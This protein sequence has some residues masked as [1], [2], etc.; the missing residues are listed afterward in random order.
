[1]TTVWA[2]LSVGAI[3]V[4]V[5][6]GYNIVF[7]S[8]G[9]FN[10]AN[11]NLLM[12]G[13]FIAYWGLAQ[14]GLPV[15]VVFIVAGLGVLAIAGLEERIAF[16]PV[17]HL[18]G[19]LV[20]S[21]GAAALITGAV[22]LI[23]GVQA[24]QV[25]FFVHNKAITFLGGRVV[26]D[27]LWLIG[28]AIGLSALFFAA[29]RWTMLGLACLA[30]SEDG[31][32]ARLR[33]VNTR[34]LALGAFAISGALAGLIGPFVGPKTY[35]FSTLAAALALKGFVAMAMGGFGSIPGCV[36]GGFVAG[37]A[38]S[39]TA[40]YIGGTYQDLMVFAL[41][42]LVLMLRPTGLLGERAERAV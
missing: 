34:W 17:K 7:I 25:P 40:R 37:M 8:A 27:E 6:L 12:A 3:Y 38:E 19:H 1:V 20:T 5:A 9:T 26:P 4:L 39:L 35:A 33:G 30:T 13:V 28:L 42:L 11:A 16:R 41:L 15:L 36:V 10:F 21:V 23:W 2:G 14:H 18:E 31:E 32:A 24:L 22:Q 29:L